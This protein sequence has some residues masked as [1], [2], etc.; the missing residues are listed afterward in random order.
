[1]TEKARAVSIASCAMRTASE[2]CLATSALQAQRGLHADHGQHAEGHHRQRDHGL[3]QRGAAARR[4]AQRLSSEVPPAAGHAHEG[5]EVEHAAR[6]HLLQVVDDAA[7]KTKRGAPVMVKLP[8]SGGPIAASP[9]AT[10][11]ADD[12]WPWRRCWSSAAPRAVDQ[13]VQHDI[14]AGRRGRRCRST[15][16]IAGAAA[17]PSSSAAPRRGRGRRRSR[18]RGRGS[19][20]AA[21]C[22]A[23]AQSSPQLDPHAPLAARGRLP[24]A[25]RR[26][27]GTS[28]RPG[29]RP[30][31]ARSLDSD[32]SRSTTSVL[33]RAGRR[34]A[35]RAG[36]HG[37]HR[38]A[39]RRR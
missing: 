37:A 23:A 22:S 18:S 7:S 34:H 5:A 8:S 11:R 30:P 26:W 36:D 13:A 27:P 24:A 2:R 39:S 16:S 33:V 21:S 38:P 15:T 32:W 20:S 1:M 28:S 10:K 25:C 19:A 6:L 3:D 4:A 14:A 31:A 17:L 35:G 29:V 12:E 9:S